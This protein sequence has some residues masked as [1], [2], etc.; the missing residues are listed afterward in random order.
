MKL[1]WEGVDV[2][3]L[4]ITGGQQTESV[5]DISPSSIEAEALTD[6]R[7]SKDSYQA[8][9]FTIICYQSYV[10]LREGG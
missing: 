9:T 4:S 7:L 3:S 1:Y 10:L 8:S 5:Q 2:E 6:L